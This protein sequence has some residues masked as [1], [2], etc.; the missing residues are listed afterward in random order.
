MDSNFNLDI[1]VISEIIKNYTNNGIDP[2][3]KLSYYRNNHKKE[4]DLIIEDKDII[5]PIEI[6]KSMNSGKDAIKNFSVLKECTNK[7]IGTGIVLCNIDKNT[8]IDT[9][10]YFIPIKY[11]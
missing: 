7:Q 9:N 2:K 4:I 5:Y 10:N 1:Y 11:I 8:P 3:L 6:K